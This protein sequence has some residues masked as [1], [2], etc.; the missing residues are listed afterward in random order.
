MA[1]AAKSGF[2]P[3][4]ENS[5]PLVNRHLLPPPALIG[6]Y[7]HRRCS[8]N[9]Y[10]YQNTE[11]SQ[12]TYDNH[13]IPSHPSHP[14][15]PIHP[16]ISFCREKKVHQKYHSFIRGDPNELGRR[17][18]IGLNRPQIDPNQPQMTRGAGGHGMS[19]GVGV[20]HHNF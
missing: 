6:N 1:A 9:T 4:N 5:F 18:L 8:Q 11:R 12:M 13:P 15:R 2:L 16:S 7:Q 14:I 19:R 20:G 3:H 17:L 10:R